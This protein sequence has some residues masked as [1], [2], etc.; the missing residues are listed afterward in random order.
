MWKYDFNYYLNYYKPDIKG[1]IVIRIILNSVS[2][3]PT[4]KSCR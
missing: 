2:N 4:A 3:T 1:L